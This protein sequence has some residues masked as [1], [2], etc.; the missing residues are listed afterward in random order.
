MFNEGKSNYVF[1]NGELKAMNPAIEVMISSADDLLS[2][3]GLAPG[4]WAY[5]A[6]DAQ[7]WQLDITGQ[8]VPKGSSPEPAPVEPE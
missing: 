6:G 8:W 2:L 4:S 5:I 3:T 7:R 1:V